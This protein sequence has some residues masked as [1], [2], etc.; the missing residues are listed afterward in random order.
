MTTVPKVESPVPF[1]TDTRSITEK[2]EVKKENWEP[3]KNASQPPTIFGLC[4]ERG[5]YHSDFHRDE[6]RLTMRLLTADNIEWS[7]IG[8]HGFLQSELKFKNPQPGDYVAVSYRGTKPPRKQGESPAY[9]YVLE[10][11]RNPNRPAAP[12]KMPAPLPAGATAE[13]VANADVPP[14]HTDDD[15]PSW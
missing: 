3:Q 8:F 12:E 13:P 11:E 5:E 6:P 2:L 10:L 9:I 7:V 14:P 15:I 1:F 4:V